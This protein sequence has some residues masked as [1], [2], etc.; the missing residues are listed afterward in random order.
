VVKGVAIMAVLSIIAVV[1]GARAFGRA[2]A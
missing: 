2:V 1:V